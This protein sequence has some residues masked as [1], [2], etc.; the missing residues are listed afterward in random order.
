MTYP[1]IGNAGVNL[2]DVESSRP[3]VEGLH[4]QGVLGDAEQL[5]R[6]ASRSA[7]TSPR[8]ASP[9]SRASTRAPWSACCA[10]RATSTACCRASISI[11]DRL[12]RNAREAPS[13]EGQDLVTRVTCDAPYDWDEG[14]L[15]ARARLRRSRPRRRSTSSSR[16]T[17][18][19]SATSSATSS[20]RRLQ[21]PRRAGGDAGRRR[22]GDEAGRR[23]PLQRAGRSRRR[24]VR[25]RCRARPHGQGA[26]LRHLP[27]PPDP[28]PGA[29]RRRPTSSSSA[30]TAAIS[31]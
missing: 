27:R 29:R 31:R 11:A 30:I 26:D 18:A 20:P 1:E 7:T 2:E 16:T 24:P 23:L 13:M 9:A 6:D 17:S 19:S 22:P 4:R 25:R 8:T 28:R 3:F 15:D 5:A 14:P 12:V 10:R 21:G